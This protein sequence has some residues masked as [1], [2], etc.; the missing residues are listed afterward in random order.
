MLSLIQSLPLTATGLSLDIIG[1]I[2]LTSTEFP[3]VRPHLIQA[4]P[5]TQKLN[6]GKE[7]LLNNDT[8]RVTIPSDDPRFNQLKSIMERKTGYSI[9]DN[10]PLQSRGHGIAV[11]ILEN[12]EKLSNIVL[13]DEFNEAVENKIDRTILRTG[14]AILAIGFG[15]QLIALV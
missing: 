4:I 10:E 1:A 14:A 15:L 12:G 3:S 8:K 7:D 5:T 11:G 9:S 13:R 6:S 2:I